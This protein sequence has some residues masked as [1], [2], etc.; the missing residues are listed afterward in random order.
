[1]SE[2]ASFFRKAE[3]REICSSQLL[4]SKLAIWVCSFQLKKER[5]FRLMGALGD[6]LGRL[7]VLEFTLAPIR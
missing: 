7:L 1:M 3:V 2:P 6:Q 4:G 5:D